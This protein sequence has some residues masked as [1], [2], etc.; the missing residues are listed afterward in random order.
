MLKRNST[1][2]TSL[3][4]ILSLLLGV[5]ILL[6]FTVGG[7][8]GRSFQYSYAPLSPEHINRAEALNVVSEEVVSTEVLSSEMTSLL[9]LVTGRDAFTVVE[10]QQAYQHR[11]DGERSAE[12]KRL[13]L[14]GAGKF[15]LC[16]PLLV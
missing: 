7:E 6:A 1:L 3:K 16:R 8:S 5:L 15:V 13:S 9:P 10:N 14:T 2:L 4:L 12:Y 11:A